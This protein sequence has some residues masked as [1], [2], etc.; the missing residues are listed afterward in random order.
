MASRTSHLPVVLQLLDHVRSHVAVQVSAYVNQQ[1]TIGE[2]ALHAA[3]QLQHESNHK[4]N[5]LIINKDIIQALLQAGADVSIETFQVR[6][7]IETNNT[8]LC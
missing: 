2:T 5:Y 4:P 3:S 7:S 8:D 6:Y 1:N